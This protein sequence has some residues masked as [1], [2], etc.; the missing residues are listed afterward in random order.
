MQGDAAAGEIAEALET[1]NSRLKAD[2]IVLTRGGGSLEDLWAFNEE[3]VALAI[4]D[5]RIPVVSAVGHEVDLTIS[6]LAADLRAPTPSA[7]AELLV[8]EKETLTT[9][10]KDLGNRLVSATRSF[11]EDLSQDLDA[12]RK[13]LKDPRKRL[14]DAWLRLDEEHARIIRI[15]E[16]L[17][18]DL[19][20]RIQREWRA[21]LIHTPAHIMAS[22]KEKVAVQKRAL[23]GAMQRRLEK[24]RA[25]LALL[26]KRMTDLGPISVLKRGYSI[27]RKLPERMVLKE[28]GSV[29][30]G[31]RV[32][33]LLFEGRM[34]C[35][36]EEAE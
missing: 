35:L 16:A 14:A 1:V 17:T 32:E 18:R 9:R 15:M 23:A 12:A 13:G 21:L 29:K 31:D 11:L 5:S 30:T 20:R 24:R 34:E 7:A 27:T 3:R 33:V 2:V 22:L 28:A 19:Q 8:V 36:V 10:L 26:E 4:R 6:D 25:D